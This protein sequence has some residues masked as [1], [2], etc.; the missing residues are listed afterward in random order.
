ME[1]LGGGSTNTKSNKYDL[2][3]E[4]LKRCGIT[5]FYTNGKAEDI[6]ELLNI[7]PGDRIDTM[8]SVNDYIPKG[9]M[10]R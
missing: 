2:S 7:K 1:N 10:F 8:P 3:P 4:G 9:S 5:G 6:F